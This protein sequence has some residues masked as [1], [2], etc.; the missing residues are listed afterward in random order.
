MKKTRIPDFSAKPKGVPVAG[1][2]KTKDK[3]PP[4]PKTGGGKPPATSSKSGR[5]GS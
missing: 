1:A 2:G 5:R 4:P 3:A